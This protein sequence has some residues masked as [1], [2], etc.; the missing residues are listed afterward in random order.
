MI[1]RF[2]EFKASLAAYIRPDEE[3]G[4]ST[5]TRPATALKMA[6]AG[7]EVLIEAYLD[8]PCDLAAV[9]SGC[10]HVTNVTAARALAGKKDSKE[11]KALSEALR[12]STL[13]V[14]APNHPVGNVLAELLETPKGRRIYR[15]MAL[16]LA[17]ARGDVTTKSWLYQPGTKETR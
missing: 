5:D 1:D 16:L 9:F 2:E 4:G 13:L 3:I 6:E 7:T 8:K 10:V 14:A 12:G 11:K 15:D 17:E